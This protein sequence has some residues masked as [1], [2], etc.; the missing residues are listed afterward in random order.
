MSQTG[1]RQTKDLAD[2]IDDGHH[3]DIQ[4]AAPI[5]QRCVTGDLHQAVGTRHDKARQAQSHN[6]PQQLSVQTHLFFPQPQD[7]ALSRK[8]P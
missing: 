7:G 5:S 6:F 3:A 1:D 8:K 4:V 2:G